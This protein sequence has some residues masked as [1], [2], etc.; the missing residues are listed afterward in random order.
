MPFTTVH[1]PVTKIKP[2]GSP[3][4]G[5]LAYRLVREMRDTKTG[6][7]QPIDTWS[8][9][10]DE[11]GTARFNLPANDDPTTSP[12][13][14]TYLVTEIVDRSFHQ[15]E[16]V[17]HTDGE[18]ETVSPES[19]PYLTE[20]QALG[21]IDI[22]TLG[23]VSRI[24]MSAS[25]V[26]EGTYENATVTVDVYGRVVEVSEGVDEGVASVAVTAPLT[27]TGTPDVPVLGIEPATIFT[28]GSMSTAD[29][30]MLDA[31]TDAPTVSTLMRR[32][33]VG[34]FAAGTAT[35]GQAVVSGDLLLGGDA[36][37]GGEL[38]AN[39]TV[40]LFGV[41]SIGQQAG[42]AAKAGS[43]YTA[44]EQAMLQKAYDALRALGLLS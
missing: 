16:A 37:V 28:P 39:G 41:P 40:G 13:G 7:V 1:I 11:T 22:V 14:A 4:S 20:L 19:G 43:S 42:G 38:N 26:V 23:A 29:K 8:E 31:A 44:T 34:G 30:A 12:L 25:G 33:A 2:D 21:P 9:S 32:D 3:S 6:D 18:V 17:I 5:Y 36:N 35:L 24:G 10:L 27:D 15:Y